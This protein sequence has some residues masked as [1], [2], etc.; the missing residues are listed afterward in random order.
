[1]AKPADRLKRPFVAGPEQVL[2]T[3]E[4]DGETAIIEYAEGNVWRTS[5]RIG[6]ELNDLTDQQILDRHNE[7]IRAQEDLR[8]DYDH[9]AL[10]IPMGKPQIEYSEQCDQW[11]PRGG[12]LRVLID[13]DMDTSDGIRN[14]PGFVIDDK[15]L[16]VREFA[17]M[18]HTWNGWGI[19]ITLVPDDELYEHPAIEVREPDAD[20]R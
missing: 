3:R 13:D 14:D 16:T 6:P 20:R 11:V 12:V 10:E 1:M 9:V 8:R 17:R 4:P 18:L 19:R 15:Q 7:V 5:L 2:I